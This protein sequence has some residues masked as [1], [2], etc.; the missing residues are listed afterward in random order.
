MDSNVQ[1][2][3]TILERLPPDDSRLLLEFAQ[4]LAEK[5]PLGVSANEARRQV[6]A[7]LVS[8]VGNLLMGGQPE[9]VP[10]ARPVWRTPVLIAGDH[11]RRAGDIDIDAHTGDLLVNEATPAR[12]LSN[13]QPVVATTP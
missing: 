9:F 7:W 8:E 5:Q 4:F 13:V 12:I 3:T 1:Y 11:R 6:S 10:G 2:L